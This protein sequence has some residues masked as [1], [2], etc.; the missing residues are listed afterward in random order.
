MTKEHKLLLFRD[1]AYETGWLAG[2]IEAGIQYDERTQRLKI[3]E[4]NRL[5][6]EL[7]ELLKETNH[8][9]NH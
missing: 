4:R 3:E 6:E 7:I 1:L 9:R 8:D 5:Q 2:R